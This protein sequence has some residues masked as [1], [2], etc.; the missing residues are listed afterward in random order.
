MYCSALTSVTFEEGSKLTSIGERAFYNC[1]ALESIVI[2]AN[3]E[4]ICSYAFYDLN[5]LTSVT[6]EEGSK[7][8]SIGEGAFKY[9]DALESIVIPASV[10]TIGQAAFAFCSALKT[11][12]YGG[13]AASWSEISIG[14]TNNS[15]SYLTDATRYYYS[16]SEPTEEGNFWHYNEDGNIAVW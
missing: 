11:V 4:S 8:K 5:T 3:V 12:Y 1:S 13:D 9:C 16:E 2:P 6:F 14:N 10:E 7:L 15:N